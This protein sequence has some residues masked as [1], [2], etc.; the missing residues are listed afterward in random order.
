[1]PFDSMG[2]LP[3]LV[4]SAREARSVARYAPHAEVRLRRDA[5]AAF[6]LRAPLTGYDIIHVATHAVVD[7]RSVARTALVLAPGGGE[8][9]FVTP[10][11][12][13][14]LGLDADLVVLS[15]CRTAG[16]VV[17]DGDGV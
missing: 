11:Q 13:A 16:G 5:S 1:D 2:E 6:L 12:L 8:S 17:I 4:E 7:E 14:A 10:A 9:G 15:A 3:R